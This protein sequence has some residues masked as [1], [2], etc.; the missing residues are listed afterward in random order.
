MTQVNRLELLEVLQSVAPGIATKD[1]IE[2]GHYFAFRGRSVWTFNGEIACRM[3]LPKGVVLNGAVPAKPLMS[4]LNKMA[5][6]LVTIEIKDSVFHVSGMKR[7]QAGIR[8]EMAITLPLDQAEA[9]G[10]EWQMLHE[11]FSEAIRVVQDCA[12]GDESKFTL[13]CIHV[14]PKWIEA[15][16]AMQMTRFRFPTGF[17]NKFIV[18]K[19]ALK[20]VAS[21]D[22]IEFNETDSWVHFRSPAG[23]VMSCRR[24]MED[25]PNLSPVVRFDSGELTDVTLPL[26]MEDTATKAAIFSSENKDDN[27]L[28]ISIKSGIIKIQGIGNS[29]WYEERRKCKYTG[30][31]V[32]FTISPNMLIEIVKRHTECVIAEG[33]LKIEGDKWVFIAYLGVTKPERESDAASEIG[34]SDG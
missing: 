7:K 27:K 19:K 29:G 1:S 32:L 30:P 8:M 23:L 16:D 33:K 21:L 4:L 12:S 10:E 31:D 22:M 6:D 5:E 34:D 26:G 20:Y 2:Q 17:K 3:K 13:T 24:Y 15:C 9:P 25:Y 18:K 28:L 14:H 11:D